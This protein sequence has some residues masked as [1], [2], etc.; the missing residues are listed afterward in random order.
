M[1]GR[2]W[3]VVAVLAYATPAVAFDGAR[4]G[5]V[6]GFGLGGGAATTRYDYGYERSRADTI[7]SGTDTTYYQ[8]FTRRL[9]GTHQTKATIATDFMLGWCIGNRTVIHYSNSVAWRVSDGP[10]I[11]EGVTGIGVC[12]FLS[13]QAPSTV[14]EA[15]GGLS[16]RAAPFTTYGGTD[17]GWGVW[18]GSG[19]EFSRRWLVRA[20]L[21]YGDL[22]N[23]VKFATLG[24]TFNWLGY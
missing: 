21:S 8:A 16:G 17:T 3:I 13:D 18:V 6:L 1:S 4:K 19:R 5:F 7:I 23:G 20:K 14:V 10:V 11:T 24:L 15:G 22:G 9:S 12:Y 2:A